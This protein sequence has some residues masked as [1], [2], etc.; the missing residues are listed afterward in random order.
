MSHSAHPSW[1]SLMAQWVKNLPAVQEMQVQYLG[2]GDPL[3]EEVYSC[4][5][6]PMDNPGGLRSMGSQRVRHDWMTEHTLIWWLI[7]LSL[8][9]SLP[10]LVAPINYRH[11]LRRGWHSG[12]PGRRAPALQWGLSTKKNQGPGLGF[13]GN[14]FGSEDK[15]LKRAAVSDWRDSSISGEAP[16]NRFQTEAAQYLDSSQTASNPNL[17]GCARQPFKFLPQQRHFDSQW[18]AF[19]THLF[20]LLWLKQGGCEQPKLTVQLPR[21]RLAA[22]PHWALW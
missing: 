5:G 13:I 15:K 3:E 20:L 10:V 9:P 11:P 14:T 12:E 7:L 8:H 17:G 16:L 22:P 18:A 19:L 6:N 4:L 21:A 2:Q 1:A